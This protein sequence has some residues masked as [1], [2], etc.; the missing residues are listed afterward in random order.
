MN[1]DIESIKQ[2]ISAFGTVLTVLKQAKDLLPDSFQKQEVVQAIES[3]ERQLKIAESQTAHSLG[4][5]LCRKHYP[6][7][8]MLSADDKIWKCPACNNE[9]D[10]NYYV[11]GF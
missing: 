2:A 1:L 9:K 5:E 7:E 10:N 8:V 11:G 4:Y 3:A 6:P